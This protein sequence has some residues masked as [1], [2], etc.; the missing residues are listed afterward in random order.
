M[1]L[2]VFRHVLHKKVDPIVLLWAQK[3]WNKKKLKNGK[4][5]ISV[6]F[7][8]FPHCVVL[9]TH[10]YCRCIVPIDRQQNRGSAY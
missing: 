2:V 7:L 1:I 3:T 5:D 4:Y 8:F 6:A 9:T 10:T